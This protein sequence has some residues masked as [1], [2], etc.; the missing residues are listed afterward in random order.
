MNVKVSPSL[1]SARRLGYHGLPKPELCPVCETPF[2]S[3]DVDLCDCGWSEEYHAAR[4]YRSGGGVPVSVTLRASGGHYASGFEPGFDVETRDA[5]DFRSALKAARYLRTDRDIRT[6]H[7]N[8]T[9]YLVLSYRS[10]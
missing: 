9:G 7:H 4:H 10:A 5:W 8:H 6:A 1:R 2:Y 3:P